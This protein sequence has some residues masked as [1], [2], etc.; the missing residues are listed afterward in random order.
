MID[1]HVLTYSGTRQEWLDQCLRSLEGENCTVHVVQGVEGNV[2]AG[3]AHAYTLGEHEFVS[4][5]DSDDYV[6]P[7]VMDACLRA[8]KRY[9]AVVTLEQRL[10]GDRIASKREGMHHL[11]VYRRELVQSV[12]ATWPDH[13]YLCDRLLVRKLHPFQLD[14]EGYVWRMHARQGHRLVTREQTSRMEATCK[15]C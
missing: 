3:R 12:L 6:L 14:F 15:S 8:L 9:P 4:Y 11:T 2:G 13:P 10:W 5:V 7:G 1:V